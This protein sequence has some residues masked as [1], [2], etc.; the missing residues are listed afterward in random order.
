MNYSTVETLTKTGVKMRNFLPDIGLEAVQ[1]EILTGLR[2][3]SKYISSKFFY[4]KKGSRLFEDITRLDEYYPTRTEKKILATIGRDLNLDFSDFSIVELGSGD[5]SKIQLLFEQIPEKKLATIHYFP[6]DISQSA[7]ES[8]AEKLADKFPM[9]EIEGL[10][11]DFVSQLHVIPKRRKRLFCFFGSTIGNLNKN[12]IRQFMNSL[13]EQMQE[14]DHFLLGLDMIKDVSVL[15]KAYNDPENITA[16]FNKNILNVINR[17]VGADFRSDFFDHLAFYN[18]EQK[19]IEMH[20]KALRDM[21]ITLAAENEK[22]YIHKGEM[23]HTENSHKFDANH[24]RMMGNW[25][26]LITE[27]ILTDK[28]HWFSLVHFSK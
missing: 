21:E 14:G 23:I 27:H 10:V 28:N 16:A 7:I 19:R 11:A 8:S 26:G 6:V 9:L 22:I 2:A 12:E 25:A 1:K 17:L 20:L 24:I 5:H 18:Q 4:D 15:N 13:G 3:N